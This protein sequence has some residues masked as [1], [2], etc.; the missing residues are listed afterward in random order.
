MEYRTITVDEYLRLPETNR[1]QELRYGVV[2]EPPAP[3]YHHQIVV[4]GLYE[5]L[6]RHVRRRKLGQVVVS[7]VDVVLDFEHA[8]VVQPDLVFISRARLGIASERVW[9]APDLVV[10]VLSKTNRRHDSV[11]KVG[12]YKTHGVRECWLVDPHNRMIDVLDLTPPEH[13]VRVFFERQ[14]VRSAVFPHLR[15][16]GMDVF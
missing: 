7:P 13:T 14:W 6:Q 5:R 3:G 1:P 9:G 8:L 10:E 11:T 16:R 4:G 15:L 12:W 2:R